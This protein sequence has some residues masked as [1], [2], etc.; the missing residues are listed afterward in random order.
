ML[1]ALRF[2]G[3]SQCVVL[4]SLFGVS[5]L[6][7]FP[8]LALGQPPRAIADFNGDGVEDLAIGAPAPGRGGPGHVV[9][10]YGLPGRN[11]FDEFLTIGSNQGD[12]IQPGSLFGWS[13]AAGDFTG[14]GYADLAVGAPLHTVGAAGAAGAVI[15]FYGG[16]RNYFDPPHV[17][18]QDSYGVRD[19]SELRDW[20]GAALSASDVTGDGLADLAIGVPSE[21][22]GSTVPIPGAGAVAVLT[23]A[24]G[25]LTPSP[26]FFL[27]AATAARTAGAGFGAALS[28]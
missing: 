13:L 3:L 10:C 24:P 11:W 21:N 18:H 15:V 9:V 16:E 23:G 26:N 28:R 6:V 27:M 7:S 1:A 17:L 14:D 4:M 22:I 2:V 12:V 20:F 5:A 19:H 25:V 8:A